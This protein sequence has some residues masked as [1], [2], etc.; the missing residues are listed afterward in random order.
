[1]SSVPLFVGPGRGQS[2]PD[3]Y[4]VRTAALEEEG[5]EF[6]LKVFSDGEQVLTYLAEIDGEKG[7]I[8]RM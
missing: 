8:S 2:R 3:V 4:L 6:Q 7:N 1:M 5:L